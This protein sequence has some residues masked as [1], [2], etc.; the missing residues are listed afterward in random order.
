MH[1]LLLRTTDGA[2]DSTTD[3]TTDG[4]TDGA[5]DGTLARHRHSHRR[6]LQAEVRGCGTHGQ[7]P[8]ES[9]EVTADAARLLHRRRDVHDECLQRGPHARLH[10]RVL[11][12]HEHAE[13]LHERLKVVKV[14]M[15]RSQRGSDGCGLLHDGARPLCRHDVDAWRCA[16]ELP[17]PQ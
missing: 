13:V 6:R 3:G 16:D 11:D 14:L 10:D 5:T 12:P 17:H 1:V 2:T 8:Q 9:R 4:A 7:A 15:K